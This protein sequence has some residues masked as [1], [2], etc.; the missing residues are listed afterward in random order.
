M[1]YK[2]N[3]FQV[4]G[5]AQMILIQ[6]LYEMVSTTVNDS[7]SIFREQ[8]FIS[9]L[10][11]SHDQFV[12][13][14]QIVLDQFKLN[15]ANSFKSLLDIIGMFVQGNQLLVADSVSMKFVLSY[16]MGTKLVDIELQPWIYSND[17]QCSC[18]LTGTC[19]SQLAL[20]LYHFGDGSN[21]SDVVYTFSTLHLGCAPVDSLFQSTFSCFF[22][23]T[24]ADAINRNIFNVSWDNNIGPSSP[25][26]INI[27]KLNVSSTRFE[28]S[29]TVLDIIYQLM[30]EQWQS[31]II[32]KQYYLT[33]QP[34]SCTY[35]F[36]QRFDF[37]YIATTIFALFGE[38]NTTLH[39]IIPLVVK[40]IRRRQLNMKI[41]LRQQLNTAFTKL[42]Q[43]V[44]TWNLFENAQTHID[45]V[46]KHRQ[47]ITTRF[48]VFFLLCTLFILTMCRF[49]SYELVNQSIDNPS[50][51]DIMHLGE[52]Y[53]SFDC[54]CT[55]ISIPYSKFITITYRQH[56]ICSSDFVSKQWQEKLYQNGNLSSY[57]A[58]DFRKSAFAQFQLLSLLCQLTNNTLDDSLN[59][60]QTSSLVTFTTLAMESFNSTVDTAVDKFRTITSRQFSLTL[61]FIRYMMHGNGIHSA[62]Q[63]NWKYRIFNL[64]YLPPLY[65]IPISYGQNCTC[66]T[67]P[68]C[69]Q[70]AAIFSNTSDASKYLLIPGTR[71]GCYPLQSL[72]QSTL[73]CFYQQ[74]CIDLIATNINPSYQLNLT[75]LKTTDKIDNLTINMLV[76]NLFIVEWQT[77]FNYN[78]YFASCK[79]LKCSYS[80]VHRLD[81]LYIL[82]SLLGLYGGIVI[83]FRA[84]VPLSVKAMF[85]CR[86]YVYYRHRVDPFPS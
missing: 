9:S 57:T 15:T 80:Y 82:T 39:L 74:T 75:A 32:F 37:L 34:S 26:S 76:A 61:E 43:T 16:S 84:I 36:Q 50:A 53:D 14:V 67:S 23:Q 71:A 1:F 10:A 30:I 2:A 31:S 46:T 45:E 19:H 85:K 40:T 20:Y 64:T 6:R 81:L 12:D 59:I 44:I 17:T 7:W 25:S 52:Q 62:L 70:P 29:S 28:P 72:L 60:F 78:A 69:S 51:D 79:P 22:D 65:S 49:F 47:Q 24:C 66:G 35:T 83:V 63:T 42:K 27:S 18:A 54:P 58:H 55:N 5:P 21:N 3:D 41:S 4:A 56:S 48:Y 68:L 11:P 8:Q 73:E 77:S 38:L 13:Q 33:C 86:H